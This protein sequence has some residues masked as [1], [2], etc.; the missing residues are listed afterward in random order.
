MC[1]SAWIE[2]RQNLQPLDD[3]R[4]IFCATETL[5]KFLDHDA[6]CDDSVTVQKCST[7]NSNSSMLRLRVTAKRE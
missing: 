7:Q 1:L 4:L 6:S 2:E 5:Q 3:A